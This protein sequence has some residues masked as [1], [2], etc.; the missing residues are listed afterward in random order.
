MLVSVF[1]S[2]LIFCIGTPERGNFFYTF[3]PFSSL[4]LP[5]SLAFSLDWKPYMPYTELFI[6]CCFFLSTAIILDFVEVWG[7]RLQFWYGWYVPADAGIG[8][9]Y[10]LS[11]TCGHCRAQFPEC[12]I[13]LQPHLLLSWVHSF[14]A[15]I[16][17]VYSCLPYNGCPHCNY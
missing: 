12:S 17:Y 15:P 14:S 13:T 3:F 5:C 8:Q 11:W 16:L 9:T 7:V 10:K 4:V 6:C 1:L 2:F